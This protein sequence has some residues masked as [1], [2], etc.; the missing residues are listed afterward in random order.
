LKKIDNKKPALGV[1][2]EE[3]DP[4]IKNDN[5]VYNNSE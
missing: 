5:D 2:D 3:I 1:I 4:A